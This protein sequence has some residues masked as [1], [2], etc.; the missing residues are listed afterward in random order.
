MAERNE[1]NKERKK[2]I[3]IGRKEGEIEVKV[4]KKDVKNGRRQNEMK[5]I[6]NGRKP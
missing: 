2:A 5:E 6:K 3:V 1:G 4:G